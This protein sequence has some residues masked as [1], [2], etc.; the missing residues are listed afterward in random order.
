MGYIAGVLDKKGEDASESILRM[1]QTASKGTAYS[2]GIADTRDTEE[3][4]EIP[5][6]TSL[7]SSVLIGAKNLQAEDYPA[8]PLNQGSMSLVFKGLQYDNIGPDSLEAANL[9]EEDPFDG[10]KNL[11]STREGAYVI[12]VAKDKEILCG[13]DHIGTVPLY[14]GENE[15]LC[16]VA[17]NKRMLWALDINPEP[18]PPGCI[19][20]INEE[21]I[22]TSSI[23][24]LNYTNPAEVPEKTALDT[25]HKTFTEVSEQIAQKTR[26]GVVAFSGGVDS[27]LVAHYLKEA[28]TDVELVSTGI[29]GQVELDIAVRAA[30]SLGLP[31]DVQ[32]YTE[33]DVEDI[34]DSVIYSV[35]ES[36]PMKIG[37]AYPF[38]WTAENAYRKG[39]SF[40]YSGNGADE[41]FGGYKRYH[42][43][44]L[45]GKDI[46]RM[47]FDDVSNSWINN[48]HRDTKTCTDQ[49][50]RLILPFTHPR[51][52][53]LGLSIPANLKLSTS[54][55]CLRKLI[56]RKLAKKVGI[57]DEFADR[58]KKA[59]QY[60][61]GVDKAMRKIA[62]RK[63]FSVREL[64]ESRFSRG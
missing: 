12:T 63:G 4:R 30:E 60:S 24:R 7:S 17:S 57:D 19:L 3:H 44:F 45:E 54:D 9:L 34:L 25:L 5:D 6:F 29:E 53:D 13:L 2:F 41:L 38:Y 11:I 10:I 48:F 42:S 49:G 33:Q 37:I 32:T 52:I 51:V 31:V 26:G 23:K 8:P 46:S 36:N 20:K 21:G 55:S 61:T 47:M 1:L 35:E 16:A 27:T 59:A 18:M 14:Y 39:Q 43:A 40:V 62:K 22:T 28:G 15:S 50:V 56:L 64:L 58:P